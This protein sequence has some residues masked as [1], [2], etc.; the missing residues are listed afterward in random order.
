MTF[1]SGKCIVI[2]SKLAIS[3]RFVE[4]KIKI[5]KKNPIVATV[6]QIDVTQQPIDEF[7]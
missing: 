7:L 6:I 1:F 5:Y 4:L 2:R 3:K